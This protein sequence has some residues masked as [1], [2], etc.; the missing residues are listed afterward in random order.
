MSKRDRVVAMIARGAGTD[1]ICDAL[2]LTPAKYGKHVGAMLQQKRIRPTGRS[3]YTVTRAKG[4][5]ASSRP[6]PAAVPGIGER[7]VKNLF[8]LSSGALLGGLSIAKIDQTFERDPVPVRDAIRHMTTGANDHLLA[9]WLALIVTGHMRLAEPGDEHSDRSTL[10][11]GSAL[12]W[13]FTALGSARHCAAMAAG[14]QV[15]VRAARAPSRGV[16][17]LMAA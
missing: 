8:R 9:T 2:G 14:R 10:A 5:R 4:A 3:A 16:C 17:G 6:T 11:M 7:T 1:A 15:I 12:A 13:T